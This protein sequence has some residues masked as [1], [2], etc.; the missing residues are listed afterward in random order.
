[1]G[2]FLKEIRLFLFIYQWFVFLS[3]F[4]FSIKADQY[5]YQPFSVL[6]GLFLMYTLMFWYAFPRKSWLLLGIID[7]TVALC[8]IA[9]TGN[10]NSPF[11]LYAYTSLLWVGL[12]VRTRH[13]AVVSLLFLAAY[14]LLPAALPQ[15][16]LLPTPMLNQ[17]RFMLDVITWSGL[18][19]LFAV[20]LK[21]S[22]KLYSSFYRLYIFR[23]RLALAENTADV[24]DLTEKLVMRV[25]GKQHVY[26]CL[27]QEMEADGDWRRQYFVQSLLDAGA[28][29]YQQPGTIRLTDF[30]A[31]EGMYFYLPL[32]F[33]QQSWGI[34]LIQLETRRMLTRGQQLWLKLVAVIVF[35]HRKLMRR[36]YELARTLHQEMRK[37]LAQDMHDG[38][39]QQLFFLSAQ[40][41]QIK[42]SLSPD[43]TEWQAAKLE[44]ME[45]RIQWCHE[46][47]RNTITHLRD[48]RHSSHI[49]DA[50][51]QLLERMTIGAEIL[52]DYTT[53]GRITEENLLVMDAIY[54]VVE[55]ATS[56]VM[57]HAKAS[58]LEVS[59][60]ASPVQIKVRVK[61][62]GIGFLL[63]SIKQQRYGV[64]GM[65][66][67]VT[68]VGG[69]LHILSK[70]NEG[71][72]IVAIIPRKAVEMYG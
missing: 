45:Q 15:Q 28:E 21:N 7:L 59:V 14:I 3:V 48:I 69:T 63:D 66:E 35:Y 26:L 27:F 18:A 49:F 31:K 50:I 32:W 30:K 11:M 51:E 56:N 46:E 39:A 44:Q 20:M 68:R 41:F 8:I 42:Q 60:D 70:P 2:D 58:V 19:F 62:N 9:L 6:I 22:K 24:C 10:W 52:V 36:Q 25:L 13:F 40:L 17:L 4:L 57:K 65:R 34:L 54:R 43:I 16:Q 5:H 47:V 37:K 29:S 67:R 61:D 23:R 38:L 71:T 55:E 53:R 12:V 72:E 64:L 1:M 33:E